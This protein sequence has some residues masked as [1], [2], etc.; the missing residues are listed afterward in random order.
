MSKSLGNAIDPVAITAEYDN[1]TLR[2]FLAREIRLG[3]D[4]DFSMARLRTRYDGELANELGNLVQRV[5]TMVEKYNDGKVP[6][7]AAGFLKAKVWTDYEQAMED[8]RTY[9]A[10]ETVWEVVRAANQYVD[11][12]QPWQLAKDDNKKELFDTL[13]VLLETIRQIAWM[14]YPFM[15]EASLKILNS[16]GVT[17]IIYEA[18]NDSL[19]ENAI[20]KKGQSL[21]PKH[22]T[23][24]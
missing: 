12:R 24:A 17:E 8:L 16:F 1:D 21:F 18:I 5:F 14:L 20:I 22:E 4:G 10:L 9:D 23:K 19:K 2:F 11:Q 15:P 6:A 13:Y 3:E 7:P